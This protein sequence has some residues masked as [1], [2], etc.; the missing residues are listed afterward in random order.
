MPEARVHKAEGVPNLV[1]LMRQVD[2]ISHDIATRADKNRKKPG[3]G[4]GGMGKIFR[5]PALFHADRLLCRYHSTAIKT[6]PL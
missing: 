3:G 6:F 5:C 1:T 2:G 4:G